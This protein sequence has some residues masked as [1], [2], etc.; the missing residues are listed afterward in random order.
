[1]GVAYCA[2]LAVAAIKVRLR[3]PWTPD[4]IVGTEPDVGENAPADG[5][6][7]NVPQRV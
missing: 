2:Q 4:A 1:L 6:L 5:A 3:P 7:V